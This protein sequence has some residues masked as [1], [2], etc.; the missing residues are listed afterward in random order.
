MQWVII[1][2]HSLPNYIILLCSLVAVFASFNLHYFA[3][4]NMLC[5]SLERVS[6]V[7]K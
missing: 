7:L 6:V 4:N 5:F 2:V 1:Y 3:C